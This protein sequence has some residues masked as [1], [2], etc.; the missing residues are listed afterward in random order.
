LFRIQ[1]TLT[2]GSQVVFMTT[3]I[4]FL[5]IRILVRGKA[6]GKYTKKRADI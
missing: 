4:F 1:F 3:C 5:R 2:L 6:G